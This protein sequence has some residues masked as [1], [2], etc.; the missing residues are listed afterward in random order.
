MSEKTKVITLVDN[1][2]YKQGLKAEHGLSFLIKTSHAHILFD[3]AQTGMLLDNAQ[4][5]GEDLM[6]VTHVVISHGHYDHTGG[7]SD[8]LELN[9]HARVWVHPKAFDN[10]YST[11]TGYLRPIGIPR[12]V[13]AFAH[14]F[15]FVTKATEICPNVWL[16]PQIEQ[17]TSYE[18][19]NPKL[20]CGELDAT[21]PDTFD[22]ELAMYIRHPDGVTLVSGCAHRGIVNT[23]NTVK[24]H[25]GLNK[26]KLIIGGTHLNGAPAHRLE[27]T[28]AALQATRIVSLMPNHCT[29]ITAYSL[30]AAR[31]QCHVAYAQTGSVVCVE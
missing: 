29:G 10:K 23:I 7:L 30:L 26:F 5:L 24:K 18:T 4:V 20:L 13:G 9:P 28:V 31:L 27:A 8:F 6:E 17:C 19:V 16:I 21:V 14:R 12:T 22:D 15:S 2:T 1:V 3:T 11:A 25:S